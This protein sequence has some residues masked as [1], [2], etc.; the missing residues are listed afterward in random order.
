MN[1]NEFSELDE[2]LK[3][4]ATSISY[5]EVTANPAFEPAKPARKA[6]ILNR[7]VIP[8]IG[9]VAAGA[10]AIS[11]YAPR[12]SSPLFSLSANSQVA[13]TSDVAVGGSYS[14]MCAMNGCWVNYEYQAGATLSKASSTGAVYRLSVPKDSE[15]KATLRALAKYFGLNAAIDVTGDGSAPNPFQYA[16]GATDGSVPGLNAGGFGAVSW[17]YYNPDSYKPSTDGSGAV[18]KSKWPS[19]E[20]ALAVAADLVKILGLSA[21]DVAVTES[22]DDYTVSVVVTVKVAGQLTPLQTQITWSSTG[23]L[24]SAG[25]YLGT[26]EKQGDFATISEVAAVSRISDYRYG[27]YAYFDYSNQP[28]NCQVGMGTDIAINQDGGPI[29]VVSAPADAPS[30]SSTS[31]DP[32]VPTDS[33]SP[34]TKIVTITKA[35]SALVELYSGDGS[36]WIV[37][38]FI[39]QSDDPCD[40]PHTV[41]SLADGII[42]LP[43]MQ[44]MVRY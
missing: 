31:V 41:F 13:K 34:V 43:T 40:Y 36:V 5:P 44:P 32:P 26:P 22:R 11:V 6:H 17:N 3:K 18:D 33:P 1:D 15:I 39:M 10:I 38:G 27:A 25:G 12:N 28:Q 14:A 30:A 29:P 35:A 19:R 16:I 4:V 8:A 23:E 20:K 7:I 37:P 2:R 9:L 24:A 21:N 42:E